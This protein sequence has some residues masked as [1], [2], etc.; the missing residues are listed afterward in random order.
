MPRIRSIKPDFFTDDTVG[1]LSVPARLLFIGTWIFAD[2]Y[3]TLDRSAKQLK[4]QVF[5]Y[6]D[7]DV[8][9]LLQ[10]LLESGL[11]AEYQADEKVFLHITGFTDHQKIDKPSKAKRPLP[12]NSEIRRTLAEDSESTPSGREGKGKE[13]EGSS[14]EDSP[15]G[16]DPVSWK[17]WADYRSKIR[18]PLK[19]VSIPA[20]QRELAAFGCNQSAVVEQSIAHGWQGLFELKAHGNGNGSKP[21]PAPRREPTEAEMT[22]A[23]RKAAGENIRQ[24]ERLGLSVLK[25][26]P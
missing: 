9:P 22:D 13:G 14:G 4:A 11:L 20:A 21:A 3:G 23:R 16:L 12:E 15:P 24:L 5:P 7:V 25:A 17:R 18:K 1:G 19:P 26:M 10:E 6:D 2:D 8:E